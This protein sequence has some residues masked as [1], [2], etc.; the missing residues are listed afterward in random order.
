MARSS[1]PQRWRCISLDIGETPAAHIASVLAND[2]GL[3]GITESANEHDH[4]SAQALIEQV[5]QQVSSGEDLTAAFLT[6]HGRHQ[7]EFPESNGVRII[8]IRHARTGGT[9]EI[10]WVGAMHALLIR[11]RQAIT[12]MSEKHSAISSNSYLLP[13]ERMDQLGGSDSKQRPRIDRNLIHAQKGDFLLLSNSSI[14]LAPHGADLANHLKGFGSVEYKA[15]KLQSWL[16]QEVS[17]SNGRFVLCQV[18]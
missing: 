4:A 6:A 3:W 8:A 13:T 2:S 5:E 10:A 15:R 17:A 11:G 1:T 12:L 9:L 18:A 7:R 16:K 14:E